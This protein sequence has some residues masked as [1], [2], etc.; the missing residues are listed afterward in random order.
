MSNSNLAFKQG[1][2][3]LLLGSLDGRNPTEHHFR[4]VQRVLTNANAY[5]YVGWGDDFLGDSLDAAWSPD[6]AT[7]SAIAPTS[8]TLPLGIA[9]FTTDADNNDHATLALGLN[10]RADLGAL[11]FE[12][13]VANHSS[14]AARAVEVGVA[15]ALSATGG[16]A[17][18]A[19]G[20]TPTA[21]LTNAVVFGYNTASTMTTW[22]VYAVNGGGTPQAV[23]TDVSVTAGVYQTL[24]LHIDTTGAVTAFIDD[25][26][27]ATLDQAVA[28]TAALTPWVTLK[29]LSAAAKE[30][31][32]DFVNIYQRVTR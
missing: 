29:S 32:V 24:R 27:V 21:V 2:S 16:W 13:R 14:A 6:L 31:R 19:H 12:A 25:V 17:F 4:D 5:A 28:P 10:W 18:S 20:T 11:V 8:P 15:G 7:G 1:A 26:Q 23:V 30:L 3:D 22:G 9:A